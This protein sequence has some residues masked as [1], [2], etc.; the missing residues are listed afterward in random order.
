MALFESTYPNLSLDLNWRL[1]RRSEGVWTATVRDRRD[2][3]M[4]ALGMRRHQA[5]A[6]GVALAGIPERLRH[7]Q[8]A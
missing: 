7:Q 1:R 4:V 2:G 6:V 8:S 3:Q 5:L